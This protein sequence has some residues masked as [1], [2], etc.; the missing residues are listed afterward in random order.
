[1]LEEQRA[2]TFCQC[3]NITTIISNSH[4]HQSS[5]FLDEETEARSGQ[6]NKASGLSFKP[7]FTPCKSLDK[8]PTRTGEDAGREFR[9][10][11]L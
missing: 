8:Y 9:F 7:V 4:E 6:L 1:M 3:R 11:I 5:C 2:S 10:L